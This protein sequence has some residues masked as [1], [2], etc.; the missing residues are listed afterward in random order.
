MVAF[1]DLEAEEDLTKGAKPK[2]R[3]EKPLVGSLVPA[4]PALK[5]IILTALAFLKN[6]LEPGTPGTTFGR[7]AT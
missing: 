5:P 7:F 6:T 2:H 4:V 1:S 3:S